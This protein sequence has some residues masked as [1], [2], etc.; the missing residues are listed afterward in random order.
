MFI[1]KVNKTEV[2]MSSYILGCES[3]S[4]VGCGIEI[5]KAMKNVEFHG[6]SSLRKYPED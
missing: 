3:G 1:D 2:V 6:N 5:G 4:G